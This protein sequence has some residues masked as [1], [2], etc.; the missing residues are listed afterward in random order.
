VKTKPMTAGDSLEEVAVLTPSLDVA[1]LVA[2]TLIGELAT[3]PLRHCVEFASITPDNLAAL[4]EIDLGAFGN[5]DAVH[6]RRTHG[7]WHEHPTVLADG[8]IPRTSQGLVPDPLAQI[9]QSRCA[10]AAVVTRPQQIERD[11]LAT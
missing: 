5:W 2:P 3:G 4:T 1:K 8:S 11:I 10:P 6:H 9:R 7:T